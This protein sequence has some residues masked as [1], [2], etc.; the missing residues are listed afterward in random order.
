MQNCAAVKVKDERREFFLVSFFVSFFV[1]LK[2]V[3]TFVAVTYE[4]SAFSVNSKTL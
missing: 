2:N 1:I 3:I 4:G